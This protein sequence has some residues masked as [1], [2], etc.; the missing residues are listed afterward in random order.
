MTFDKATS[1]LCRIFFFV[2]FLLFAI[3][4]LEAAAR[5]MGYTLL[6][7]SFESGRLLEY[8]VILLVFVVALLLRQIR[9]GHKT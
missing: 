4:V 2:S 7:H 6:R 1:L 5:Q 3:A 8:A 9:E